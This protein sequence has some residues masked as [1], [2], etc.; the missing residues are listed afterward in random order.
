MIKLTPGQLV[1]IEL[2]GS[3]RIVRAVVRSDRQKEPLGYGYSLQVGKRRMWVY[4]KD[5]EVAENGSLRL[6]DGR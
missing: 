1:K 4:E 6:I 2:V 3:E 5:L